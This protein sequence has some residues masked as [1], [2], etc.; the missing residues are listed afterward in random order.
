MSGNDVLAT[1]MLTGIALLL[2]STILTSR[3][4][5]IQFNTLKIPSGSWFAT[6]ILAKTGGNAARSVSK[7]AWELFKKPK[8]ILSTSLPQAEESAFEE[9]FKYIIASS[10]ILREVFR[11]QIGQL[12]DGQR[13]ELK[14]GYKVSKQNRYISTSV[15]LFPIVLAVI[16]RQ[17]GNAVPSLKMIPV[18]TTLL[19]MS[20][21]CGFSWYR[22]IRH[23]AIRNHYATAISRLEQLSSSAYKFDSQI[24]S[25]VQG[26]TEEK[27][28]DGNMTEIN[29]SS[30]AE[31]SKSISALITILRQYY[32]QYQKFM[33][34]L[35]PYVDQTHKYRLSDMYNIDPSAQA[36]LTEEDEPMT[37]ENLEKL[38]QQFHCKRRD[39]MVQLLA[40]DIMTEEHDS[41]RND[42]EKTWA[43]V[44]VW[45][46]DML[47][48]TQSNINKVAKI[49]YSKPLSPVLPNQ[50]LG[51]N[52]QF[53]LKQLSML[54]RDMR[55]VREKMHICQTEIR[56][57]SLG[58][59]RSKRKLV[60]QF[61]SITNDIEHIVQE[62]SEGKE[63][64]MKDI[65]LTT[66]STLL[67]GQ[68]NELPSPPS[69]PL[70]PNY[71]D[72]MLPSRQI[73]SVLSDN[74]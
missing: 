31:Q 72:L 6:D 67:E 54:D 43:V 2:L 19:I 50:P 69:S 21:T 33:N 26:F 12:S 51:I 34:Q 65:R 24:L 61:E 62:W 74:H 63:A 3:G 52:S 17:A 59:Q 9:H 1:L 5:R 48:I 46:K 36:G 32:D 16:L 15:V 41:I 39:C 28:D 68:V 70:F 14:Y 4:T 25:M 10:C 30:D 40:L 22:H 38:L 49:P 42:Y 13:D 11:T 18:T 66:S 60:K 37:V 57:G 53:L 35:S 29:S 7:K 20:A 58:P 73:R 23:V 56:A 27:S 71:S 8:N 55:R 45:L 44:N 47:Q 64:L